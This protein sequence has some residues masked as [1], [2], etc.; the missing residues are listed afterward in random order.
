MVK[1][2]FGVG[3]YHLFV[4]LTNTN[5]AEFNHTG[6]AILPNATLVSTTI[7]YVLYNNE[8]S[9]LYVSLWE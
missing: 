9:K 1:E 2:K 4:N 3:E 6:E 7:S 8:M 5:G